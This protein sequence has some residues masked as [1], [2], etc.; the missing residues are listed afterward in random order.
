MAVGKTGGARNAIWRQVD[1]DCVATEK[2]KHYVAVLEDDAFALHSPTPLHSPTR[3]RA[4]MCSL[5]VRFGFMPATEPDASSSFT[6]GDAL[7]AAVLASPNDDDPRLV[8]ADWLLERGDP[9][10]EFIQIQC[11]LGRPLVGA[12]GLALR[13]HPGE[14]RPLTR[15]ELAVREKSLLKKHQKTWIL[16]I[17]PWIRPWIRTWQWARGFVDAVV[18]D[19]KKFI[20][21][22][23]AIVAAT[24][25][26]RSTLTGLTSV[27]LK[28]LAA[29]PELRSVRE[30]VLTQQRIGARGARFFRS[31]YLGGLRSLDLKEY[32]LTAAG[33]IELAGAEHLGALRSLLAASCG[34]DLAGLEAL[35]SAAFLPRLVTLDLRLD[36][37]SPVGIGPRG[38]EL[39][40]HATS[41]RSLNADRWRLGDT[42]LEELVSSGSLQ[43]LE[44]ISLFDNA[45]THDGVIALTRAP[46]PRLRAI[47][48]LVGFH[49]KQIHPRS[50]AAGALRERF[51]SLP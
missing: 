3:P 43:H 8:Y 42:G 30:L 39:L 5:R 40:A 26:E 1:A 51:G 18:A 46:L 13:H 16:P 34:L 38:G 28:E 33:F 25:L 7:L 14:K 32:P 36:Y 10:G 6:P 29:V 11:A 21:R 23:R 35:A 27:H 50:D 2:Q 19:G 9:R 49:E 24:P 31:P 48:G 37:S 17:R 44:E 41:L 12:S 47:N 22:L 45:I 4:W 15:E 20:E